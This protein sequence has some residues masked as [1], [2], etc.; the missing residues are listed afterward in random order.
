MRLLGMEIGLGRK[1]DKFTKNIEKA[2]DD[3]KFAP[4]RA[5]LDYMKQLGGEEVRI[6]YYPIHERTL[7]DIALYSDVL[8]T[9]HMQLKK[10]IFRHGYAIEEKFAKKCT[11]CDKE[12]K[13]AI[14]ECDEC[15]SSSLNNPEIEQKKRLE[16]FAKRCNDNDQ[17]ILDVSAEDNDDLETI[18][19]GYMLLTKDYYFSKKG[20]LEGFIPVEL[21]RIHPMKIRIIADQT[22]RLGRDNEGRR[23]MVCVTHRDKYYLDEVMCPNCGRELFPA[24]FRGVG[25]T[26]QYIYY[27]K[28]E[29]CHK[30]K[31]K[32]SLT[33]GFPPVLS[34]WLKI[35][36]L[37]NQ[38]TYVNK[39]YAK[40]RPPRGLLFINTP[41]QDTVTKAW[42]WMLD[43]FKQ[44][45]HIIPP[46]AVESPPGN[47]G[48]FV[49]FIDF[50]RSLD[51]MQYTEMRNEYRRQIGALYGVMPLFQADLSQSGGLNNEG[52]QVTVTNRA[53]QD[54]Q[55]IFND[56]YYPW[57]L[58]QLKITDYTL[59][60]EPSEEQDEMADEQ[61]WQQKITNARQM[62]M[63]GF[64]VTLNEDQEFEYGPTEEVVQPPQQMGSPFGGQ[65]N[66]FGGGGG[67]INPP[68]GASKPPAFSGEPKDASKKSKIT[69]EKESEN[70]KENKE[71]PEN[72]KPHKFEAA[73]WTHPNGHPRCIRCGDEESIGGMCDPETHNKEDAPIT[74]N[75]PGVFSPRYRRRKEL[76]MYFHKVLNEI[77]KEEKKVLSLEKQK[78]GMED[79]TEFI[80]DSLFDRKFGDMSKSISDRIKDYM[81]KALRNG[82]PISRITNYIKRN[83]EGMD[84]GQAERIARTETQALQ[85]AVREW[86]YKKV[87]PDEKFLYRWLNPLDHRTSDVCKNIVGRSSRGVKLDELRSIVKEESIKGGFDG[88][89]EWTPH[90]SCRSS[91]SRHFD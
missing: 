76:E 66:P 8:R 56:G 63:I 31:Y 72:Q 17:D 44:N 37:M 22:G 19:D 82:Y 23:V 74:T 35:S 47:R 65:Q 2:M 54:G 12:F 39:Y 52:L 51:E 25:E 24:H 28:G 68:A 50:M 32:P 64:E 9:V 85:N 67:G 34:I 61:L 78:K 83:A 3:A 87:D 62:Q 10:E 15:G 79:I 73:E 38:D 58:E 48:K 29:I 60:L 84:T 43:R 41:N 59:K 14:D 57:L 7:F 1:Y 75:T 13:H 71:R 16:K 69:A 6:P 11:K 30:S 27:I 45:P 18:D 77:M 53:I 86:S 91:W 36:T 40:Q 46:I 80:E 55:G 20:K 88:S 90:I 21:I 4:L 81:L 89:R 26:D 42:N 33:Y 70:I 5:Q 49:E